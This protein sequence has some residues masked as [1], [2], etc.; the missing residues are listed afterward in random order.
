MYSAER[1][2]ARIEK[3]IKVLIV[4]DDPGDVKLVRRI[5][6]ESVH[7]YEVEVVRSIS[8]AIER[9]HDDVFDLTLLDLGLPDSQG[10]DTVFR[11]HTECPDIPIVVLTGHDDDETGIRAVQIGAQDYL[12]KEN[13][14]SQL[15]TRAIR[16]AIERKRIEEALQRVR[17]VLEIRVQERTAELAEAN[18]L[19]RDEI[20]ERKRTEEKIQ[21]ALREKEELLREIH[22]RVKNNLQIISSLLDMQTLRIEDKKVVGALLDSRSR[23][24][25][26]ALIH[27]QLYQSENLEEVDMGNTIRKLVDELLQMYLKDETNISSVVTAEGIILPISQVI[28]LG[29]IINELVANALKHAFREMKKGC[30]EI[31]I[32]EL[33]D[34]IIKLTVKDDGIGIP[35]DFDASNTKTL[36]LKLVRTLTEQQ[37]KGKMALSRDGGTKFSIKYNKFI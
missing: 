36:G 17:D 5:L 16:Y 10:T 4:E 32:R 28:P 24:Q 25:T 15:L 13:V 23:I 26:M 33:A 29:L 37:L 8:T 20:T 34:D 22:H 11:I 18:K 12:V 27:T 6:V 9:L 7:P 14:T 2:S 19:L 30:I 3:P 1:S 31:S 35:E 21:A